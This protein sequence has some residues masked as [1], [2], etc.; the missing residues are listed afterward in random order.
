MAWTEGSRARFRDLRSREDELSRD[1]HSELSRLVSELEAAE[2][3]S[4]AEAT[5]RIGA[6]CEQLEA[7]NDGLRAL[8]ERREASV[9]RLRSLIEEAEGKRP[10]PP[11]VDPPA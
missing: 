1:E 7:E 5:S 4:L 10:L 3:A 11:V 2:A 9:A 6:R 8:M